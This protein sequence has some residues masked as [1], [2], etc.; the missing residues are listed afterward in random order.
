M[1]TAGEAYRFMQWLQ[2]GTQQETI[3][4]FELRHRDSLKFSMKNFPN[5]KALFKECWKQIQ[6]TQTSNSLNHTHIPVRR[7]L[8]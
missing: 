1:I 4:T 6:R 5:E 2:G 8:S 3:F 7:R